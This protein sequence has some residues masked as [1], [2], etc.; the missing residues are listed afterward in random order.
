MSDNVLIALIIAVA[1]V[2]VCGI[3]IFVLQ[4][5]F[6]SGKVEVSKDGIKGGVETH[7]QSVSKISGNTIKGDGHK[8]TACNGGQIEQNKIDGNKI[9]LDS[10]HR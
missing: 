7:G 6:R 2:A 4:D 1:V 10:T 3:A 8:L 5:K 9:Q